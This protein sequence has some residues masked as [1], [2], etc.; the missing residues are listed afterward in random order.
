MD[1][2]PLERPGRRRIS[3]VL[4]RIDG[5]ISLGFGMATALFQS[6]IFNTAVDLKSAGVTGDGDS[7]MES[8]LLTLSGY[9]LLVGAMLLV[10]AGVPARMP[11]GCAW[12]SRS[13]T[14]SWHI[15]AWPRQIEPG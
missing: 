15:R 4:L 9:Y 5:T 3:T 2:A 11:T 12:S 6:A 7:L 1:L 13:I 8:A 14:G 10:L